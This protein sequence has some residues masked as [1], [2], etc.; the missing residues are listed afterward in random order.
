MWF[1]SK[2][3]QMMIT[4]YCQSVVVKARPYCWAIIEMRAIFHKLYNIIES[5]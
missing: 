5:N 2:I 3:D 1:K 4:F